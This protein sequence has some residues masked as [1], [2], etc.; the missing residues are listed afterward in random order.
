MKEVKK[1]P[2]GRNGY[3]CQASDPQGNVKLLPFKAAT[4]TGSV[5]GP[6][7]ALDIE[8]KYVNPDKDAI[9][10]DYEFPL[11]PKTIFS[12]L[13]CQIDDKKVCAVVKS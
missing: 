8:M 2:E 5:Q 3:F 10:C 7:I 11:D 9:E 1:A 13:E 6:T 12:A 4:I